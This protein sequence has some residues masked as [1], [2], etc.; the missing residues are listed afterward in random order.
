MVDALEGKVP[1][2]IYGGAYT[3][4]LLNLRLLEFIKI[5]KRHGGYFGIHTNGSLLK[6]LEGRQS[7][8]SWICL[9][10]ASKKDYLSISLDAGTPESHKRTKSTKKSWF[11]EIIDG[12]RLAVKIR[13]ASNY[14]SIRVCYLLNEFNSSEKEIGGIIDVMREIGVNSLRF[15]IPYD[16]YGKSFDRV[17]KYKWDVE[18]AQDVA[19]AEMLE[20]LLSK[21]ARDKPYVFYIPPYYQD[22]DRMDF[23]QCIYSYYQI[24]LAADGY[25]YKCSSTASP[26]FAMN[27]LGKITD[28]L[29][30][31]ILANHDPDFSPATCFNAGAKCNRIALEINTAWNEYQRRLS[32]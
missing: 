18:I 8:L 10:A 19:W 9:L 16:V 3:E 6:Q 12:I 13:G 29:D 21:D 22:V 17:R 31:M 7:F 4:P 15:S 2:C 14:P 25:V 5:T 32:N 27:R 23:E 11:G 20:P 1:Y 24:T 30:T 26:T 28:D